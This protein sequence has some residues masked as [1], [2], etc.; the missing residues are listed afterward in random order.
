MLCQEFVR[1]DAE[2]FLEDIS[3][4]ASVA[5]KK[6]ASKETQTSWNDWCKAASMGG[7]RGLHRVTKVRSVVSPT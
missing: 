7:A 2:Q 3:E 1:E 5:V 4:D 6:G